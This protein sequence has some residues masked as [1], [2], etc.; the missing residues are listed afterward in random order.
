MFHSQSAH[1]VNGITLNVRDKDEMKQFYE[2]IIGMNVVNESYST[3]QYEI[4]NLNHFITF[5][6]VIQGR[7]PLRSEAGL[8]HLAIRL[9]AKTDLADLLDRKSVV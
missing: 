3:I 6:Q 4:G 7:E 2:N 9:P 1:F 5:N 8:F